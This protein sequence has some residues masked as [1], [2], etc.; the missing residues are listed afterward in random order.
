VRELALVGLVA[1]AFGLGSYYATDEFGTFGVFNV[2][3]GT[4]ALLGAGAF[5]LR[6]FRG[7]GSPDARRVLG[8]PALGVVATL[9]V[10]VAVERLA[11]R[12]E[13]FDWTFERRYAPSEATRTILAELR[14]RVQATLFCEQG[15]PRCRSTR[16]RLETLAE[17]GPLEV[18]ERELEE[19]SEAAD[20]FGVASSNTVVFELDGGFETVERPSEGAFYEALARL[21]TEP[22]G[23]LYVSRGEGEGDLGRIDDVGYSGLAA[24]LQTEGYR[25]RDLVLAAT[26]EIPD[27][28]AAVLLLAPERGIPAPAL[29]ALDRYLEGGGR[30][31]AFLEIGHESGLETLLAE[32]G[33]GLPD[34]LVVDPASGPLQGDPPGVNPIVYTYA[35]HPIVRSLGPTRMT[36]FL[37][38]RPVFATRKPQPDDRLE[39]IAFSS[40]RSWLGA[41]LR[42][43]VP[44]RPPDAV[45]DYVPLLAVGRYPRDD[46][47]ARIVVFGD[48]SFATNQYLR[49]LYNLDLVLN[50][51]HWATD[52]GWRL[53]VR[54][55]GLAPDQFPLTPQ[56]TLRMLYGV[57]LLLPE[58]LLMAGG[59]V[60]LRRRSG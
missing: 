7:M 24:Q 50:A 34:Q 42:D 29:A 58:L 44:P 60:W 32:W 36:F 30:L 25:L 4:L 12:I 1:L 35:D 45:E 11:A 55:K 28:A 9:A 20:R 5:F 56:Q 51:V 3:L 26:R 47:E 15:D 8:P 37:R 10:A 59:V 54:P 22:S 18:R 6:S 48:A 23:V 53:T 17:Y 57:G 14:E 46:A 19:A 13:P 41:P 33:F 39:A 16:V 43:G 38:A 40:R 21:V 52:H 49:A 2:A 31:V 27:D